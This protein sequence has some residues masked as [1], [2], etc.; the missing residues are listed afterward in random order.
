ML[1]RLGDYLAHGRPDRG[2]DAE[3]HYQAAIRADPAHA[4][5]YSG[6]GLL[7]DSKMRYDEAA[8][9]YEK[10]VSLRPDDPLTLFLYAENIV[11]RFTPSGT[12]VRRAPGA[13][14]PEMTRAR[15]LY[16]RSIRLRPD[17]AEAYA[18]LGLTYVF[19]EGDVSAGI[20]ALEKARQ[21]LPSRMDIVMNLVGLY[22]RSDAVPRARSRGPCPS[23]SRR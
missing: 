5:A 7:S 20:E 6:L 3:A 17:V 23:S 12:I 16:R 21:M 10:A 13:T 19:A 14:P 9:Y 1:S 4:A 2:P 15:E 18:G 22:A 8:R 11:E